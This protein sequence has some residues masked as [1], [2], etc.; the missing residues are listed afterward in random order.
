MND[1]HTLLPLSV[2]MLLS[3]L[4]I[5]AIVAIVL[6]PRG[7]SCAPVFTAT[8]TLVAFAVIG[9]GAL[10]ASRATSSTGPG[11]RTVSLILAIVLGIGFT[12]LAIMSWMSCPKDGKPA[13]APKWLAAI[14][15]V[16]PVPAAGLGLVMA[17]TNTKNIPLELKAGAV[18]GEAQ[19]ATLAAVGLCVAVALAGSLLLV[20]PA[21]VE[22][23]GI[24]QVRS[25]LQSLKSQ[26]ISHNSAMMTVL[27]AILAANELAQVIHRLTA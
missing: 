9:L 17:V 5:V 19:L 16:T 21:V 2:G 4:P 23:T 20:I 11:A 3:P 10:G 13:T 1:L 15:G 24:S 8:F 14:D 7:R 27:F 25:A 6:A 26:L 12:V 18:I 22:L